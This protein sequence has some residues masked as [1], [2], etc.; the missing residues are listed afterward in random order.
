MTELTYHLP[1]FPPLHL[2]PT[3]LR[4]PFLHLRL[5][6]FLD[7]FSDPLCLLCMCVSYLHAGNRYFSFFILHPFFSS[8]L[9]PLGVYFRLAEDRNSFD[10]FFRVTKKV[11]W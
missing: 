7:F 9:P 8:H 10:S 4:Y 5:D 1:I 3:F 11:W 6:G 2:P